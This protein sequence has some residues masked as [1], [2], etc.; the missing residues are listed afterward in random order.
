MGG[1]TLGL[2]GLLESH[3]RIAKRD[4]VYRATQR[5]TRVWA[6]GL[7]R[8]FGVEPIVVGPLPE[9]A[10]G[11]RLIVANHRSPMDIALLLGY[12]GGHFLSRG[13]LANW[14]I[15]G[16]AARTV[17]TIFV[18]RQD[19]HSGIAAIRQIRTHLRNGHTVLVFPEGTTF[20][21]DEVR[22]FHAGAFTAVRGLDVELVPVGIAYRPGSEFFGETFI[23]YINRVAGRRSTRVAIK[24]G[25]VRLASGKHNEIASD[26]Q[27]EVQ[28]LTNDARD[29]YLTL[30]ARCQ[31][32]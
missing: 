29:A 6:R 10:K 4:R 21:G 23:E 27:R 7:V 32:D 2:Y 22:S 28:R 13:D 14:P 11:A 16:R 24:F 5:F 18:D 20:A 15:L 19:A 12:C 30:F 31:L 8:L 26:M 25:T 9:R 1:W 3:N 17:D